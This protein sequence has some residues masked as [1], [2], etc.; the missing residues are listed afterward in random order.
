MGT[1]INK[2]LSKFFSIYIKQ[3][4]MPKLWRKANVIAVLKPGRRTNEAKSYRPIFLLCV[5]FKLLERIILSRISL[6]VEAR[7]SKTQA[8][9]RSGRLTSDQV[10]HSPHILDWRRF[11]NA[12]ENSS[13]AHRSNCSIWHDLASGYTSQATL[14]H[15]QSQQGSIHNGNHL[16]SSNREFTLQTSNKQQSRPRRLKNGVPQGSIL[17]PYLFNIYISDIP[18]THAKQFA[19]TDDLAIV[20]FASL[21]DDIEKSLNKDLC[22]LNNYYNY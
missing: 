19:F 2:L 5:P 22:T 18:L 17:A 1:K 20:H 7:L 8:G 21:W 14:N 3:C 10:L 12:Q 15:P 13:C 16:K 9:S 4:Y 6:F 11:P